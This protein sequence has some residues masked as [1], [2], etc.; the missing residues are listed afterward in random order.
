MKHKKDVKRKILEFFKLTKAKIIICLI[1]MILVM[2]GFN[3]AP[4]FFS[5]SELVGDTYL[6]QPLPLTLFQPFQF[7]SKIILNKI[8]YDFFKQLSTL[9]LFLVYYYLLSCIL[10]RIW[11]T[12]MVVKTKIFWHNLKS[13]QGGGLIGLAVSIFILSSKYSV[14]EMCRVIFKIS[15]INRVLGETLCGESTQLIL[16]P[17]LIVTIGIIIGLIIGWLKTKTFW[18]KLEYWQKGG[19]IGLVIGIFILSSSTINGLIC[20]II[21]SIIE[22]YGCGKFRFP[23]LSIIVGLLIGL[24]MG[25]I[26]KKK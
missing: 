26:K 9:T 12:K 17:F 8:P 4:L 15:G 10:V 3:G 13:W 25:K 16:I 19:L 23:I 21:N 7:A 14:L 2:L 18:R 6:L 1:F 22:L 5:T 11:K 24:I 20:E